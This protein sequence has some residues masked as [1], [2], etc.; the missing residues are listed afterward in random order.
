LKNP[1]APNPAFPITKDQWDND[2]SKRPSR[3]EFE[4]LQKDKEKIQKLHDLIVRQEIE[5]NGND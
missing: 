3:Q 4:K 2:Y 5:K 1:P